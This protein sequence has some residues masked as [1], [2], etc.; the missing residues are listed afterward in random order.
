MKEKKEQLPEDDWR[1]VQY[2]GHLDN[3]VFK[4]AEFKSTVQNDH[5]HCEFCWKKISDCPN[6]NE[7]SDTDGYYT[8]NEKAKQT[9]WVCKR[10][11]EEFRNRFTFKLDT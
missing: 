6:F 2:N 8:M 7:E 1:L 9:N 11:F 10:C 4:Y 3:K 5:E